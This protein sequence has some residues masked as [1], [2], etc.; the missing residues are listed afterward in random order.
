MTYRIACIYVEEQS[1]LK[2]VRLEVCNDGTSGQ[3]T[4]FVRKATVTDLM[5]D[6]N[7]LT[8]EFAAMLN[9]LGFEHQ[10]FVLRG[11]VLGNPDVGELLK[12][13]GYSFIQ[14][15]GSRSLKKGTLPLIVG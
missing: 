9:N 6:A 3:I 10:P 2:E 5:A 14:S 15:G 7:E 4:P 11:S 1:S 8:R 13:N 12:R